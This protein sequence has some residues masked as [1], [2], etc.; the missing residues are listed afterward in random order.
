MERSTELTEK[1]LNIV[2]LVYIRKNMATYFC[3]GLY[4]NMKYTSKRG[5]FNLWW[6][7]KMYK[8]ERKASFGFAYLSHIMPLPKKSFIGEAAKQYINNFNEELTKGIMNSETA[9]SR[10]IAVH[11]KLGS[12]LKQLGRDLNPDSLR[13]IDLKYI[14]SLDNWAKYISLLLRTSLE[15]ETGLSVTKER[16]E[17]LKGAVIRDI[18]QMNSMKIALDTYN[19]ITK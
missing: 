18:T 19:K 12:L 1:E 10:G 3:A 15:N 11:E 6:F 13:G 5:D 2:S 8:I 14:Y 16:L 4:V 17:D 9:V 7:D